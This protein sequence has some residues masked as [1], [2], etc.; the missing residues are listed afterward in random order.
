M[1]SM[2]SERTNRRVLIVDDNPEIHRDFAKI[3]NAER[4]DAELD[5]L[6]SQLFGNSTGS[7]SPQTF[8]LTFALQGREA[9]QH[10]QDA[11]AQ[12]KPFAMAFVDMR[13]PPGWDGLQTIVELWKVDPELQVVICTA[14]SDR[15]IDEISRAAISSDQLVVL[16]KPFDAIEVTQLANALTQ[17]WTLSR[18]AQLHV[19]ELE[20]VVRERT[21][22]LEAA[23]AR[24]RS[25]MEELES[26]IQQ[27]TIELR[28]LA[29]H[30]KLTNLPNRVLFHDRLTQAI[31]RSQR[32]PE[33]RFAVLFIDFDRFKVINDSMGHEAG[34][35]L[36]RL[37]ADR[38]TRVLREVDTICV[39]SDETRT[40]ARLG[41]DEFCVLL[42]ALRHDHDA[43]RVAER[44][45]DALR[46]PYPIAG[47]E[48]HSSA[49]I[50]ITVSSIG[51]DRAEDVIRDA[52]NAMYR[53]KSAGKGRFVIFDKQMHDDA[54][55]R[56]MIESDL[57]RAIEREELRLLFQPI[58]ALESGAL[59]GFEALIRWQHPERG[60]VPPAQ[61]IEIAEET[62]SIIEIGNWV[63][64]ESC[65]HLARW[66]AELPA[67]EKLSVSLNVSR[68]QLVLDGL[69][70]QFHRSL[71]A[72]HVPPDRLIMEITESCVMDD[73]ESTIQRLHDISD[74]GVRIFID[75]FGTGYSSLSCLHRLPLDGMKIDRAFVRDATGRRDYI[76]I[77]HA[78]VTLARNL[79][80]DMV[81]EGI[82]SLEH[83][84]LLQALDCSKGQGYLFSPPLDPESAATMI[85]E[86][87]KLAA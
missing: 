18:K 38:L 3:L 68:K 58:T 20:S 59:A 66:R 52:D 72:H 84:A 36:L 77:I 54:V 86:N 29:L 87:R 5:A 65:R 39:G 37:I 16:K 70:Q 40:A 11:V 64:E 75:D 61:F 57:R 62:G 34:D 7:A 81:A 4:S 9:L 51:Y 50:G 28:K 13:M 30:D 45:L 33:D 53:A 14:F 47:R 26:L 21:A 85:R 44:I 78:I 46:E 67:A 22:E 8:E 76:A 31:R 74:L 12:G 10:V 71:S 25:R 32:N 15:S 60:M 23:R 2:A 56:M 43:A 42:S 83:V 35:A 80:M 69:K 63:I 49:S 1:N 41:G 19:A 27:R 79:D 6:E 17:K 82:E 55:R 73:A 48:V 24:D